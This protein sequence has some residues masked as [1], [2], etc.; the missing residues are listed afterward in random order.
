MQPSH[1]TAVVECSSHKTGVVECSSHTKLFLLSVALT[2]GASV[3]ECSS[4]IKL[5]SSSVTHFVE[6]S[7]HINL[8]AAV[9]T[10]SYFGKFQCVSSGPW[11]EPREG[12]ASF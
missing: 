11:R 9:V 5:V 1:E 12:G 10:E 2:Y 8:Y 7:S 6:C 4:P 3:I